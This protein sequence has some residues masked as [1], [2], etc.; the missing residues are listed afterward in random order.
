MQALIDR[1]HRANTIIVKLPDP[2]RASAIAA[3]L[4]GRIGYK[5][6]SWQESSEDLMSMLAIRNI[7]MYSVVSA[8]LIVAA[9]GIYNVIS[10]VVMEKHRDIALSLNRWPSLHA[11]SSVIL[12]YRA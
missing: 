2:Y 6:I 4:E 11:I 9:F 5:S 3:D 10:T 8:V 12:L 1:P 7:I